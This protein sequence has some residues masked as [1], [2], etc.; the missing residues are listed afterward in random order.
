[1]IMLRKRT[2]GAALLVVAGFMAA[3]AVA[4]DHVGDARAALDEYFR[5]WNAADNDAIA[6]SCI[7][8]IRSE[9]RGLKKSWRIEACRLSPQGSLAKKS[10]ELVQRFH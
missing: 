4:Q 2:L 9:K 10:T 5:A 3:P 1:M 6:E 8:E 7:L